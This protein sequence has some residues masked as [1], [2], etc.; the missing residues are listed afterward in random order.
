MAYRFRKRGLGLLAME[1]TETGNRATS[2][3][4]AGRAGIGLQ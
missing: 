2:K 1:Y 3:S 4:V